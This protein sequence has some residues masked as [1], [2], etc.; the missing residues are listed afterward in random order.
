MSTLF[1]GSVQRIRN[2]Q[3]IQARVYAHPEVNTIAMW[4]YGYY[5]LISRRNS[6]SLAHI[7]VSP[8]SVT[9]RSILTS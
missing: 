4:S 3:S 7:F 5:R 6:F 1:Q 8:T 2:R 9:T